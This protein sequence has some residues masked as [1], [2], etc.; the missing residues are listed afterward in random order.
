MQSNGPLGTGADAQAAAATG[1]CI[2]RVRDLH[3]M[4]AQFELIQQRQARVIGVIDSSQRKDIL[5]TYPDAIPFSL[6][7]LEI[8]ERCNPAR[9]LAAVRT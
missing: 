3:A 2:W 6:T 9:F 4:H 7:A 5:R 8:Y 1:I